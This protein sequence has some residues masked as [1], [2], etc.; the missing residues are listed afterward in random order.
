MVLGLTLVP[1]EGDV[2]FHVGGGVS[3]LGLRGTREWPRVIGIRVCL[4]IERETWVVA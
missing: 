2:T 4:G 3:G 1:S